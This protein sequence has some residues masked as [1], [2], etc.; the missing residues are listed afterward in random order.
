MEHIGDRGI[1]SLTDAAAYIEYSLLASYRER[2]FGLWMVSVKD[3]NAPLGICGFLK[4]DYLDA[5]DI[6]FAQLPQFEGF[7]YM[8]EACRSVMDYG[9]SPL[10]FPKV[11]ALTTSDNVRSQRLLSKLGFS[12]IGTVQPSNKETPF[13]LFSN[14]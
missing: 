1:I 7:G 13:L 2:G 5:P 11:L 8:L 6:G 12:E 9:V 3:T 4:R 10:N 14:P